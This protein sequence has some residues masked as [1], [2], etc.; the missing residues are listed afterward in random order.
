[1]GRLL[2]W[3]GVTVSDF[4]ASPS[5][6]RE[7]SIAEGPRLWYCRGCGAYARLG[8]IRTRTLVADG[9]EDIVEP[10]ENARIMAK[11]I[12]RS[13]LTLFSRSGHA[14]LFQDGA[15]FASRAVRFLR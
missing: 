13:S 12:R 14:F 1:V 11:R 5:I 4:N 3:P 9:R 15:A 2:T 7:Q 8:C 6:V 10:P